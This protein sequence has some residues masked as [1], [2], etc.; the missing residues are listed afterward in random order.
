MTDGDTTQNPQ[1]I[2]L[3]DVSGNE[4]NSGKTVLAD[5]TLITLNVG[6]RVTL[7]RSATLKA[8]GVGR[9]ANL[10][11]QDESYLPHS[12]QYFFDRDPEFFSQIIRFYR[13]GELHIPENYCSRVV[14]EELAFWQ[15]SETWIGDCCWRNYSRKSQQIEVDDSL[16]KQ[17]A[18]ISTRPIN[19]PG[20]QSIR[21]T[22][23][24][25]LECPSSSLAAKVWTILSVSLILVSVLCYSLATLPRVRQLYKIKRPPANETEREILDSAG[26]FLTIVISLDLAC[27]AI[28]TIEFVLRLYSAPRMTVVIK[29]FMFGCDLL[30]LIPGLAMDIFILSGHHYE[31]ITSAKVGM[32]LLHVITISRLFRVFRLAWTFR[33]M[34][35]LIYVLKASLRELGVLAIFLFT[36]TM[37]FGFL[38]YSAE[39]AGNETFDSAFRGFWWAIITMTTVG[40]GDA[41]PVSIAGYIIAAFCAISGLILLALPI[42]IIASNFHL[43]YGFQEREYLKESKLDVCLE[44][45]GQ[46]LPVLPTCGKYTKKEDSM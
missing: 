36:G 6:G 3:S 35:I 46:G 14:R 33:G 32:V 8:A 43:Y 11:P 29:T 20:S 2:D 16:A 44:D 21:S 18:R 17:F 25:I 1:P 27:L 37:F 41:Y 26:R 7:T 9:L 5:D 40:Y 24:N 15:L 39:V 12:G 19:D 45:N 38:I 10:S 30:Y 28:F 23:W 31:L 13:T 42:P 34:R 22:I 4:E